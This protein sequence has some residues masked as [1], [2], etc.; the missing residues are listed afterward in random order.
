MTLLELEA[1]YLGVSPECLYSI[2]HN[3][4]NG[5]RVLHYGEQRKKKRKK[6]NRI[7]GNKF[8]KLRGLEWQ[9]API[10]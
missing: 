8:V 2:R 5:H 9:Q 6:A 1:Q 4:Q 3:E 10:I 7:R